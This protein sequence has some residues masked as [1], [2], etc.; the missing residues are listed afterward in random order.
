MGAT[1]T[2]M[3]SRVSKLMAQGYIRKISSNPSRWSVT[4]KITPIRKSKDPVRLEVEYCGER[5][6]LSEATRMTGV[7]YQ[8]VRSRIKLGWAVEDALI[9]PAGKKRSE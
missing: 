1:Y 6:C 7:N 9:V 2:K 4:E 8:T 5:M 3:G